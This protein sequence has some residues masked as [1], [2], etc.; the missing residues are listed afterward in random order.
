M[1]YDPRRY[2]TTTRADHI[3]GAPQGQWTYDDY[4]KIPNDGQRY[5]VIDGVLYVQGSES[6]YPLHKPL[7]LVKFHLITYL[8]EYQHFA[9]AY[10]IPFEVELSDKTKVVPDFAAVFKVHN[11]RG[12]G[13]VIDIPDLVVE[14]TSSDTGPHDR[15]QKYRVYASRG[16]KEYWI[17]NPAQHNV[18]V[19]KLASSEYPTPEIFSGEQL[20]H[21]QLLP[22]FS[23]RAKQFFDYD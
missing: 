9:A 19:V 21:S 13:Y 5:E 16:V 2:L 23:V 10:S 7:E 4:A 8:D 6:C 15:D 20:V 12:T 18:E 14:V 3:P 17:V 22:G 1:F 11:E